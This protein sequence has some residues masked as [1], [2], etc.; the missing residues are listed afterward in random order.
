LRIKPARYQADNGAL[1]I[2]VPASGV[3]R[4]VGILYGMTPSASPQHTIELF[5]IGIYR[6]LLRRRRSGVLLEKSQGTGPEGGTDE[7]VF[8]KAI[9]LDCMVS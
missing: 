2:S 7:R 6:R 9:P 5:L 8:P 3:S 1:R 4:R